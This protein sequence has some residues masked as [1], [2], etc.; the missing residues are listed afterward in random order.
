MATLGDT[1]IES[2]T[3]PV[4]L[5]NIQA[6]GPFTAGSSGSVTDFNA[7]IDG[8]NGAT[9]TQKFKVGLYND[10]SGVPGS[11]VGGSAEGTVT[12]LDAFA[13]LTVAA[14]GSFS[15]VSGN[16]YWI[17]ILTGDGAGGSNDLIRIHYNSSGVGLN[18]TSRTYSL[19]FPDPFVGGSTLAWTYD[20]Y[21]NYTPSG[22]GKAIPFPPQSNARRRVLLRR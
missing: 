21:L 12:A 22:S 15:I 9:G 20:L 19:G 11:F 3:N 4:G 6:T 5:G 14:S 1:T 17:A 2:S 8:G 10:N 16:L 7:H 18:F 13:W